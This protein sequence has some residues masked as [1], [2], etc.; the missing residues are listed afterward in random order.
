ML[1]KTFSLINIMLICIN[2]Q[3]MYNILYTDSIKGCIFTTFQ[4]LIPFCCLKVFEHLIIFLQVKH[5]C[6]Y[7]EHLY[8]Y[9]YI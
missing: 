5:I 8:H 7:L 2:L 6:Y 4:V 3:E 1:Y 9:T